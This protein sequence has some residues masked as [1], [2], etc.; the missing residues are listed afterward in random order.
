MLSGRILVCVD[1]SE[2]ARNAE[3]FAATLARDTCAEAGP[4]EL[5]ILTVV[6][7]HRWALAGGVVP[8][9]RQD[10]EEAK[11]LVQEAAG[12]CRRYLG[13]AAITI[14]PKIVEATSPAN[15]IVEESLVGG[16]CSLIV[17]GHRGLGG[18]T[19]LLLGSV[20]SQVLQRA[21]CPVTVVK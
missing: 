3:S 5:V 16:T 7:P 2:H 13:M 11:A 4:S 15:G 17:L 8:P 21:E 18:F 10:L 14:T 12:R 6:H 20:A 9:S 19:G 1:G